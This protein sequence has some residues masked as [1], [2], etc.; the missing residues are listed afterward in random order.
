MQQLEVFFVPAPLAVLQGQQKVLT[1]MG[2]Q[3]A[4]FPTNRVCVT[5]LTSLKRLG[6]IHLTAPGQCIAADQA[7]L[8]Q[9][10]GLSAVRVD[11]VVWLPDVQQQQEGAVVN[12]DLEDGDPLYEQA[13]QEQPAHAP[14]AA[15]GGAEA[16]AAADL[17]AQ[18]AA[19]AAVLAPIWQVVHA[20][21]ACGPSLRH[22]VVRYNPW[23][24]EYK[25]SAFDYVTM[26]QL[27][28]GLPGLEVTADP[29]SKCHC[30]GGCSAAG[31]T[32]SV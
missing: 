12:L 20:V 25:V 13:P 15:A 17:A 5:S 26:Q 2:L 7:A 29:R 30:S 9:L 16:D 1:G 8:G 10:S 19:A 27:Q 3:E 32:M 11:E 28:A 14:A 21:K 24:Q 31:C 6:S 18:Q 22:V 4:A 23:S